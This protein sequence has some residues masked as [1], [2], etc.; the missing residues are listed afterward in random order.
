MSHNALAANKDENDIPWYQIEVIIF[1]NQ[2]YLGMTSETWP[3]TSEVQYDELIEL[4]HP[5]DARLNDPAGSAK[6]SKLPNFDA[7]ANPALPVPYQLLDSS[8]LQLVP[9]AK[10]LASS[11]EYQVITHIAWRQPTL[12][13]SKSIPVFVFEGVDLPASARATSSA[14]SGSTAGAGQQKPGTSR[15][16]NVE[17]GGF[18]YDSSQYGQLLPATE[19]DVNTGPVLNPFFGTLRLSVS[20]YLHLEADLNYR[21]PVLKEEVVPLDTG[22]ASGFGTQQPASFSETGQQPQT[23]IRKR[24]ALQNFHMYES[25]RMRSKELHYF[26]HPMIGL[27]TRVIPY[28][29]PKVEAD[30]D[31]ASQAFTPGETR[32]PQKTAP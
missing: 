9:V 19:A 26:D 32:T 1:A 14:L 13:S 2:S 28:E 27:I 10:K 4:T 25:R 30:F 29:I 11:Q 17:V 12:D 15:F 21:I 16:S 23:T 3:E 8:E 5:D 24:Q 31:P 6:K 7:G 18:T 20:R 22:Y